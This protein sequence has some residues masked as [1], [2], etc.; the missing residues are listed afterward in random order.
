MQAATLQPS[1]LMFVCCPLVGAEGTVATWLP[2]GGTLAAQRQEDQSV[3][4]SQQGPS[5]TLVRPCQ[6]PARTGGPFVASPSPEIKPNLI[7]CGSHV[8][9][10]L[11][12]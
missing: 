2:L 6:S 9:H 5:E 8:A 1:A 3:L 12:G 11:P 10:P 7:A 4:G